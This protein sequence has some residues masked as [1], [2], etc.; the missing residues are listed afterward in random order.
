M[1]PIEA[2]GYLTGNWGEDDNRS[3][4]LSRFLCAQDDRFSGYEV[5]F[6]EI[7]RGKKVTHWIWYIFPQLRGLGHSRRSAYYGISGRQE[8]EEYLQHPVLGERLRR[9]TRVLL[10]HEGEHAE[11]IFGGVDAVKVQSCMTLFDSVS[12][13][14]IFAQVLDVFYEGKRDAKS[15]V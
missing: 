11:K 3:D 1:I 12:P 8:A 6:R 9:I 15:I 4:D 13:D 2:F 14:D 7:E 5:A 10:E